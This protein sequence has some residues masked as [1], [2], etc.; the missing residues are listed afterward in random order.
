MANLKSIYIVVGDR[1]TNQY[2]YVWR[3]WW[4]GTSFY[5]KCRNDAF[6][7][8]KVSLY[9]A[10]SF[11]PEPGFIVGRDQSSSPSPLSRMIDK[12]NFLG[13]RFSGRKVADDVLHIVTFRFGADLFAKATTE[14][15]F[16]GPQNIRPSAAARLAVMPLEGEVT[17]IHLDLSKGKPYVQHE[18]KARRENAIFGPLRNNQ[19][20]YLTGLV[21]KCS[22]SKNPSPSELL[23]PTP[24]NETD[25]V[26]G[27]GATIDP[28]GGFLWI[29]EQWMSREALISGSSAHPIPQ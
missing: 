17:D 6:P 3:I 13:S 12:S 2:S 10:D 20:E 8:F 5:I 26:H 1:Q 29:A 21:N 19:D 24:L 14:L 18:E 15:P 9:G 27:F 23:V 11:H 7:E 16:T 22:L 4:H 25:Q 28:K